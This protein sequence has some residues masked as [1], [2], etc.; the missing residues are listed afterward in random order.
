MFADLDEEA[1]TG[2]DI[3]GMVFDPN[4]FKAVREV[5]KLDI[6]STAFHKSTNTPFRVP[7][8]KIKNSIFLSVQIFQC[9]FMSTISHSYFTYSLPQSR[10]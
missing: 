10:S 6:F 8:G 7:I 1:V 2:V 5:N 3:D 4:N 9:R